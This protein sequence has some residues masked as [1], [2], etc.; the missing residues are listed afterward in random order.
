M[1][2]WDERYAAAAREGKTFFSLHP[3]SAAVRALQHV[4][5]RTRH[6]P[7]AIDV[8]AGEGRHSAYLAEQGYF[9]IA[10][11]PSAEATKT[12]RSLHG[13]K[14]LMWVQADALTWSQESLVDLVLIAYLHPHDRAFTD[15][16][17][18]VDT[19]IKPGGWLAL[20][21]HSLAQ[22]GTGAPGPDDAERLWNMEEI[23]NFLRSIGYTIVY[24][25]NVTR[26]ETEHQVNTSEPETVEPIDTVVTARKNYV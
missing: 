11:E 7:E 10:L 21:G 14:S 17:A 20:A 5:I 19:W 4:Q 1:Q 3:S 16:L 24:A 22:Y 12:G 8:G 9:V 26:A 2:S 23:T 15:Y 18:H 25:E 6:R 13:D